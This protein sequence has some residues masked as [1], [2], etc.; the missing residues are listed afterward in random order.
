MDKIIVGDYVVVSQRAHLCGGTH[1]PDDANFQLV[2]HP[3]VLEPKCWIASEA[4]VGP[5]VV[6]REGALVGA[7]GVVFRD[8]PAWEIWAGNPARKIR[9]R[10][11]F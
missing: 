9:N 10:E 4:F 2:T 8:V 1:D 11:R 3:I 7:R 5:G 6:V